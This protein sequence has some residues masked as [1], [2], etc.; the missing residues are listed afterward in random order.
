MT[1]I[2]VLRQ[3]GRFLGG[4]I[5][6]LCA[7]IGAV[8]LSQFP[9]FFGQYMQRL[10]GHLDEAK[11]TFELYENT[12]ADLNLTLEAYIQEHLDS[13]SNVFV[14]AGQVIQALVE[15]YRELQMSY[16]ALQDTTIY[17]RWFV[18]LRE[19]DWAIVANTWHN[20]VPGVPTTFEGLTY[21]MVGLLIGWG[22]FTLFKMII[23]APFN[24]LSGRH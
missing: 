15:R 8:T 7:V 17:N 22:A 3:P 10:G 21:A 11:R 12:A 5:D 18:F 6:R 13:A 9:Q 20:F 14:S 4:I 24:Y 19:A 23:S 2:G 16:M 1:L